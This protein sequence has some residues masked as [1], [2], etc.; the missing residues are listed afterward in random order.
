MIFT[1]KI[2]GNK[3]GK[4]ALKGAYEGGI[5]VEGSVTAVI[6]GGFQV[7]VGE[8]RTFCPFSQIGLK[9]VE[10][11]TEYVGTKHTFK[12]IEYS[13]GGRNILVSSRVLLEEA[14]QEKIDVLKTELT[15]GM[16]VD[17]TVTSLEKFGAF[18][19]VKGIRALLPIS[20]IS[21]SRVNDISKYLTVGQEIQASILN[22]DWDNN[23]ISVS[24]KNL[25]TDPWSAA[26]T[27]YKEDSKHSGKVSRIANF[28]VF[29]TLESGIDGLIHQSDFKGESMDASSGD[30]LK[31]GQKISVVVRS[32]DT[33][34]KRISLK[35]I[36][37]E[38]EYEN[39]KKYFDTDDDDNTYN[40]FASLLK[41]K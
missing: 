1:T 22:L 27:K 31:V 6:K 35:E 41:G 37:S 7:L 34:Q 40:P 5:P 19:E 4:E 23:K 32:I 14:R 10:D 16:V 38:E 24:M 11:S 29:V 21:R 30:D 20:E 9:R 39:N 17:A 26:T 13:E 2:S 36:E 8:T 18:V 12:I 15:A 3:A 25:I 28:G 33:V